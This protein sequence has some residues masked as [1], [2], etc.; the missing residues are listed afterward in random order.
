[1][2]CSYYSYVI[3]MFT[4]QW[5]IGTLLKQGTTV[6]ARIMAP[7]GRSKHTQQSQPHA[8]QQ[9]IDTDFVE[10]FPCASS[11]PRHKALLGC[12]AA[13]DDACG[14]DR[15]GPVLCDCVAACHSSD[16]S[17]HRL[18]TKWRTVR[19]FFIKNWQDKLTCINSE[20]ASRINISMQIN[21]ECTPPWILQ[22][23]QLLW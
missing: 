7:T 3:H 9:Q 20:K 18:L 6:D 16:N 1:M 23:C 22:P 19:S 10:F 15:T 13:A 8:M 17:L 11:K 14:K 21:V 5:Y 2:E 12:G 4:V